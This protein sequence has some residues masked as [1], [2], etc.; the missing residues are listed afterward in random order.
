[1]L[2]HEEYAG[3]EG[4]LRTRG[5]ALRNDEGRPGLAAALNGDD[6]RRAIGRTNAEIVVGS[7]L[8]QRRVGRWQLP[9]GPAQAVLTA[10]DGEGGQARFSRPANGSGAELEKASNE[11]TGCYHAS[12]RRSRS[13]AAI[14]GERSNKLRVTFGV[15]DQSLGE[16]ANARVA[17]LRIDALARNRPVAT[18]RHASEVL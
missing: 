17:I 9:D 2:W 12:R 1:M 8:D 16:I 11:V 13:G 4:R 3:I 7:M 6:Q 5:E 18:D 10:T 14:D 15:G